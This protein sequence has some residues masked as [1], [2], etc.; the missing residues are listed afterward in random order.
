[1]RMIAAFSK[2]IIA[3][4]IFQVLLLSLSLAAE[5]SS[6]KT[7]KFTAIPDQNSTELLEKFNPLAEYLSKKL[8]IQVEYVAARDYQAS[9][10]MFKNGD[11]QL[12]WFGGLTGV[13][14][15]AAVDGAQAIAQGESDPRYY[16]YFIANKS[17]G[18]I[19]SDSFPA[20]LGKFTFTFGSRSSTSGRL[21]PEFFIRKNTGKSPEELFEKPVG[22][23]GSHDKTAELVCTGQYQVGAINYKV[24]DKMHAEGKIDGEKCAVIWTTP[25]YADYNWTVHPNVE[26][27]FGSG[28]TQK[29]Q[30]ALVDINNPS[31]L[32]ALPREKLI[33]AKN[34]EF[35][36]I[37]KVA[38]QLKMLR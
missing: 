15:R 38:R 33:P 7:L 22:F 34:E 31:L 20:D 27:E 29:L 9:V 1:M 8:G 13:Q 17:T 32:S 30:K 24:F 19:K 36:G 4:V 28:F 26:K 25:E 18:L 21:M 2:T 10:E 12:A 37:E 6:N 11:T 35:A 3:T 23:S 14:A 16:S 5:T